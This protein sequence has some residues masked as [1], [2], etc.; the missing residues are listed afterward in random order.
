VSTP[1]ASDAP[2]SLALRVAERLR[3]AR[4]T[5]LLTQ[6][7]AAQRAGLTNHSLLHKYETGAIQPSYDTLERIATVYGLTAAALLAREDAAVS[8]LSL[9]DGADTALLARLSQ[10][11]RTAL[12]SQT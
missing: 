10:L 3:E 11:L 5:A 2:R 1:E 6:R 12:L 8:L 9:I 7:E 4:L